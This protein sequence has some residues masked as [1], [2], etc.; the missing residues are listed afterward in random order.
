MLILSAERL[1]KP[2]Y[3]P[4]PA[5]FSQWDEQLAHEV[6][7]DRPMP[8][9]NVLGDPAVAALP[10]GDVEEVLDADRREM[11]GVADAE[12][13]PRRFE[14]VAKSPPGLAEEGAV[15]GH[16]EITGDNERAA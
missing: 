14:C 10:G 9:A 6:G 15:I 8:G 16:V 13:P 1:S 12:P 11:L 2:W 5:D 3:F 7:D 4:G